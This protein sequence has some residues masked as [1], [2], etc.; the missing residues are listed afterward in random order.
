ML[1]NLTVLTIGDL[2]LHCI[3]FSSL[4]NTDLWEVPEQ[5]GVLCGSEAVGWCDHEG[6]LGLLKRTG[7]TLLIPVSRCL[8]EA[9]SIT[10]GFKAEKN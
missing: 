7:K 6:V 4:T 10:L 3:C 2:L 1:L 8:P 9:P 5:A